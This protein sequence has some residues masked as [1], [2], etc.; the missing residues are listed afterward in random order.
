MFALGILGKLI[1]GF[2]VYLHFSAYGD[3]AVRDKCLSVR[4]VCIL[5][6]LLSL[7]PGFRQCLVQLCEGFLAALLTSGDAFLLAQRLHP[8]GIR[9]HRFSFFGAFAQAFLH[10]TQ[11]FQ[12]FRPGCCFRIEQGEVFLGVFR[13]VFF[14]VCLIV[15]A[16]YVFHGGIVLYPPVRFYHALVLASDAVITHLRL[17]QFRVKELGGL[18]FGGSFCHFRV[19]NV[20]HQISRH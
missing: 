1:H 3:I 19:K 17:G 18:Q 12:F 16:F 7:C 2:F 9:Q 5:Q 11:A 20:H 14:L 6:A 15:V 10:L 13:G 8:G 4:A